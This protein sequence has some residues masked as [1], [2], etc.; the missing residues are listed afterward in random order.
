MTKEKSCGA[1][2]FRKVQNNYQFV[3]VQ[4]KFNLHF[5]FPKGH[6][7]ANETENMTARREVREETGLDIEIIDHIKDKISYNPRRGVTKD[8]VYFLAEAK[9]HDLK[10][11]EEEIAKAE[12]V[13]ASMVL[14]KL[15]FK[16]DKQIFLTLSKKAKINI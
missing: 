3:L 8:V 2:I 16:T 9:T 7:E 15:T 10:H 14:S 12:W 1:I 5:G 11:Q 6:V 4:S 13:D